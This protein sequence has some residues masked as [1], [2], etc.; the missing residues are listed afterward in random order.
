[1]ISNG[2][3]VMSWPCPG[4]EKCIGR[5]Q[6]CDGVSD[7]SNGQ[8]EDENLC[9]RDFCNNGFEPPPCYPFGWKQK[10][11]VNLGLKDFDNWIGTVEIYHNLQF[12]NLKTYQIILNMIHKHYEK[13]GEHY[14]IY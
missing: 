3:H 13:Y 6:I 4:E 7:C 8:D 12:A 11:D 2:Y 9:T 1:M 10:P 14:I 5:N